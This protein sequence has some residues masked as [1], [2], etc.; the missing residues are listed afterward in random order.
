[1]ITGMLNIDPSKRISL[2]NIICHPWCMRP[3]QLANTGPEMLAMRLT[4]G[5]R[6]SGDLDL[7]SPNF[8]QR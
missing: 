8:D 4:Q 6:D 2:S 7:A 3:S 1:M 5:I